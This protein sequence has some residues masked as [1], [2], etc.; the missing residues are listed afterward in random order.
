MNNIINIQ[1]ETTTSMIL[2]SFP[3]GLATIQVYVPL[4]LMVT[5]S[6]EYSAWNTA[7]V[8]V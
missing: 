5:L 6:M 1:I 3:I 7:L 8:L 4:S 2:L